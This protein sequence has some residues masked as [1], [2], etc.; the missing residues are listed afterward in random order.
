MMKTDLL[1]TDQL[2]TRVE[3]LY[4]EHI[5][6]CQD[7]FLYFVK[8]VWPEFLFRKEKDP[9]KWGHHQIIANEF[10]NI[11][12]KKK[13]RLIVNMPPRHTKSEF[14]SVYYPADENNAGDS[15]CRI[16]SKVRC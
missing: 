9:E 1:T 12:T 2:R 3:K 7:N 5:K 10:T 4:I 16:I 8:E 14:A 13:G 11:S 6:L 15:Q